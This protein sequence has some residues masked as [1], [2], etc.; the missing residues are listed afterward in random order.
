MIKKIIAAFNEVASDKGNPTAKWVAPYTAPEN[1]GT[2]QFIFFIKPEA[3]NVEA[4]VHLG[5]VVDIC[6]ERLDAFNVKIGGVRVLNGD[7]LSAYS[8]MDQHYGVI[9]AIS[10]KGRDAIS[11]EAEAKL[12]ELFADDLAAGARVLG[13]HQ[14]IDQVEGFTALSLS[15]LN[16]NLGTTK[17][18]GGTYVM[19]AKVLGVPYLILNPFHAYQLVPYTTPGKAIVVIEGTSET[20]WETL[21][22]N[23]AGTTDPATAAEG[24]IRNALLNNQSRTGMADVSQGSN[25]VHLSAGPLE[26]M[27]EL[28]RFFTD[29]RAQS[30]PALEDTAFGALLGSKGVSE[31][32]RANLAGN[33]DLTRNDKTVSAFD[34]TEEVNA[35]EAA[36]L[37][38]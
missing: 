26:G 28:Q 29:H 38:V 11:A 12:Q 16:D 3:T 18:A 32:Q 31:E 14:S 10:K 20:A 6:L 17:L 7:Y 35:D 33:P 27:V 24:S 5:E 21:R 1:A 36:G 15:T 19:K 22:S 9:N 25:G 37:L 8:V 30:T 34:L 4:G 2:N 13:G 23:L